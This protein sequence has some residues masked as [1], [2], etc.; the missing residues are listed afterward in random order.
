M[1][2]FLEGPAFDRAGNLYCVDLAHGRIFRVDP[3]GE[4]IVF[5][6]YNGTP[7]GLK[8]HRDGRIFVADGEC[9]VLAFDPE[10][11]AR[12]T[13][14]D[15]YQGEKFAGLNDLFFADNGDL[16]F[17]N[18]GSSSLTRPVDRVYR[19]SSDGHLELLLQD[20]PFPNGLVLDTPQTTLHVAITRTLSVYRTLLHKT[21]GHYRPRVFLQL[22]GGLAG[23][24][25]K[26]LDEQGNLAVAHTGFGTAWLFSEL[27]EAIGRIRSCA[28]I[29]TTNVAYGGPDRR[30]P[31][32]TEAAEG[33][34]LRASP[35]VPG[36]PM[37]SHL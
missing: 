32:I 22:S 18:P 4:W 25:G 20:L 21:A 17:T 27:C 16:F 23:P 30:S 24:D 12:T 29:R 1:H 34:I 8:I 28:G 6:K 14:A 37:Y 35:K 19:L 3:Q 36:R 9:G 7:N 15:S 33:V 26:A 2:S 11:G 10:T 31:Y 13:I 5:A